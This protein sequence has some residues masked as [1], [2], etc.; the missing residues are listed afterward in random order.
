MSNV[1]LYVSGLMG[2]LTLKY[3]DEIKYYP[4][5]IS[6][7]KNLLR[8]KTYGDL[9]NY[10]NKFNIVETDNQ[11]FQLSELGNKK[12]KYAVTV[13]WIKDYFINEEK[14]FIVYHSHPSL[15]PL[16]RGYGAI[17]HQFL[18]GVKISGVTVYEE[19]SI[20]DGGDIIFQ[21]KININYGD[22]PY[23]FIDKCSKSLSQFIYKLNNITSFNKI[24]QDSNKAFYIARTRNKQKIIDF[25]AS[26]INVY[27]FI[28]AYAYP[29]N[30]SYFYYEGIKCKAHLVSVEKWQGNYGKAGEIIDVSDYGIEVACGEGSVIIKEYSSIE[31]VNFNTEKIINN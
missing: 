4:D 17:S 24:S 13:D 22:I 20:I 6:L 30:G 10:K 15:L 21:E 29:F 5:V 8:R 26:A 27:N 18:M 11:K 19:N 25:N 16:Y 2:E 23:N 31:N 3:L 14:P 12:Y 28:T 1:I 9:S 7:N